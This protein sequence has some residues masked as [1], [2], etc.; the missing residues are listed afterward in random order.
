MEAG[1][2]ANTGEGSA[3]VLPALS[4]VHSERAAADSQM[5]AVVQP[6]RAAY[7]ERDSAASPSQPRR[8]NA[9]QE[10]Q[11]QQSPADQE[12]ATTP[13]RSDGG[14]AAADGDAATPFDDVLS[15]L[16][17]IKWRQSTPFA[18][19]PG[20]QLY[21]SPVPFGGSEAPLQR[22]RLGSGSLTPHAGVGQRP[23]HQRL[24]PYSA[25][26]PAAAR[27]PH[28]PVPNGSFGGGAGP[29]QGVRFG[30]PQT[31]ATAQEPLGRP[32]L[33]G[34]FAQTASTPAGTPRFGRQATCLQAVRDLLPRC[35]L[36]MACVI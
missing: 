10:Q 31:G 32:Q 7:N 34:L 9:Q 13:G 15:V 17:R 27:Q 19:A 29:V 35:Y 1:P 3:E 6:D 18:L 12:I 26:R 23:G 28:T 24:A 30:T 21:T 20:R 33:G 5:A 2:T 14:A 11:R 8:S 22:S 36:I 4:S 25:Q 16:E